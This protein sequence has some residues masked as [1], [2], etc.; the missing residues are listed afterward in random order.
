MVT[1]VDKPDDISELIKKPTNDEKY[2]K[3][4]F[5]CGASTNMSDV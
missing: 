4:E 2:H 1:F 5:S 3:S